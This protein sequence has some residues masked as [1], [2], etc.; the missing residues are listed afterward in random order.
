MKKL[1]S[2]C[3][4]C[5]LALTLTAQVPQKFSYQA[6]VRNSQGKLVSNAYVGLRFSIVQG[7]STGT[8]VYSETFNAATNVNG[9]VSVEIGTGTPT[10]TFASID[11]SQ[12][13][14]FLKTETDPTG[15]I[16]YTITGT[17]QFL[18]VP[19]A[20]YAGKTNVDGSET[21]IVG[22]TNIKVTGS[23]TTGIP[24]VISSGGYPANNTVVFSSSQTWTVPASVSKIKVELWGASGGGGGGGAYT[25]S[26]SYNLNNGGD[27]GSGGFASE[28]ID[29]TQNQQFN[30]IIGAGGAH[31]YNA[32]YAGYWYGDSDGG[33]GG[34]SWFGDIKAAGGS[35]GK[36]GSYSPT[37][38]HGAAGTQNVGPIT[39][40]AGT[41]NSNILDVWQGIDRS[42]LGGRV[43][44]S[45]PG[46]GGIIQSYSSNIA[47][48]SGEAGYAI[49]TFFE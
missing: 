32:Y 9:L 27:G 12:G 15:G 35:A 5:F 47:P 3:L 22:G 8:V 16:N 1:I 43:L 25:Y 20:L 42:Y 2:L 24:Y 26:Y 11:W 46:K 14:Y 40:Y 13:P 39:G 6:V 28:V 34:D 31:G 33:N 36:R 49:V 10:G 30:V 38:T 45:K 37:T 21:K 44:T 41:S 4:S 7:Y 48:S 17:S 29:V 18:S 19:Y 23:G